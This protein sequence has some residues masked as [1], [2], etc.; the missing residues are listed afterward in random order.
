MQLWDLSLSCTGGMGLVKKTPFMRAPI[1]WATS[2]TLVTTVPAPSQ[3]VMA[4]S[5]VPWRSAA[6]SISLAPKG[7]ARP[8]CQIP[9]SGVNCFSCVIF[10]MA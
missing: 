5:I 9:R 8:D 7:T 2:G 3:T 6:M 1:P 4:Q 10:S